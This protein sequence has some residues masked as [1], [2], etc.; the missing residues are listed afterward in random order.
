MLNGFQGRKRPEAPWP[1]ERE[2]TVVLWVPAF[3]CP[4]AE[5]LDALEIWE[6]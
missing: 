1:G 2:T 6:M 4:F 5:S 3:R